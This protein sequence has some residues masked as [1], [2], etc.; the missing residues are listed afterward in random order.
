M[1]SQSIWGNIDLDAYRQLADPEVDELVAALLPKKGSESIGRLGYNSML[2]MADK[3][4]QDPE[5]ALVN[6]SRLAKWLQTCLRRLLIIL[7]RWKLR[8][9]SMPQSLS[10]A[11][12]YGNSTR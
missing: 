6:N 11:L 8:I 3:L 5:L 10:K 12:N 7:I 4:I 2:L 1:G 9:G